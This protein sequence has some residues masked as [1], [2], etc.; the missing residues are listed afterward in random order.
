V[1]PLLQGERLI[2]NPMTLEPGEEETVAAR[3][4]A[5]LRG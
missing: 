1:Q 5:A 2:F 3:L 4:R